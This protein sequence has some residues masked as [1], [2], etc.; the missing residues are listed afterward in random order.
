MCLVRV[1]IPS[2]EL[3]ISCLSSIL[4]YTTDLTLSFH[5][6]E[7]I[8]GARLYV[9][10]KGA[11]AATFDWKRKKHSG[12]WAAVTAEHQSECAS[13]SVSIRMNKSTPSSKLI[14]LKLKFL[15]QTSLDI[16]METR[17]PPPFPSGLTSSWQ[18]D[19]LVHTEFTIHLRT[20][21]GKNAHMQI[22]YTH[23]CTRS[24]SLTLQ[25]RFESLFRLQNKVSDSSADSS[26]LL[27]LVNVHA[28][29]HTKRSA[30]W[31]CCFLC[32]SSWR[33]PDAAELAQ[34]ESECQGGMEAP[35]GT[36]MARPAG[37]GGGGGK[38]D[39]CVRV[40]SCLCVR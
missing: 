2:S 28:C 30:L 6:K 40:D 24:S 26:D 38:R 39:G 10:L 25:G 17:I 7:N 13:V 12:K 37:G 8:L 34:P 11:S 15:L 3:I 22:M 19:M 18:R 20:E 36:F 27:T 23:T 16:S 32:L 21:D 1:K 35:H 5:R 14:S 33:W 9:A 31:V 4:S 29:T